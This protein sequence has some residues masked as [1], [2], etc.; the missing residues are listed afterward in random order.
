MNLRHLEGFVAIGQLGSFSAAALEISLSQ[1]ALTQAI[2]KMET[3]AKTPLFERG[4]NGAVPT[5]A[6]ATFAERAARAIELINA[7]GREHLPPARSQALS[8]RSTMT[9]LRAL[10]AVE[11]AGSFRGGGRASRLSE[12][13]VHRSIRDLERSLGQPLLRRVGA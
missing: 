3:V 12:P 9:Q 1:S 10:A 5:R 6:G 4:S 2:A 13:S 7:A 11:R 8:R